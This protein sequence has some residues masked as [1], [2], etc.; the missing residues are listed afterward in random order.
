MSEPL[1]GNQTLD[2]FSGNS[3]FSTAGKRKTI[4][5]Y[6]FCNKIIEKKNSRLLWTRSKLFLWRKG[7]EKHLEETFR[8]SMK[9]LEWVPSNCPGCRGATLLVVHCAT[10]CATLFIIQHTVQ[11]F[12]QHFVQ[13]FMQHF[14]QHFGQHSRLC[15][16]LIVQHCVQHCN[17]LDCATPR[18]TFYAKILTP[19]CLGQNSNLCKIVKCFWFCIQTM[20]RHN[21]NW[22]NGI[23]SL[24]SCSG[25]SC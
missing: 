7:K 15:N 2:N 12:M 8:V 20:K 9:R 14:G 5:K 10:L 17:T 16:T 18:V 11:H 23:I 3:A 22:S 25:S 19:T 6:K 24:C 1:V 4:A 13:H 21:K